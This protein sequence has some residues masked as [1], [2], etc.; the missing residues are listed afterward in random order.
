MAKFN[1][2]YY[3]YYKGYYEVEANSKEEAEEI[4]KDDIFEGRRNAPKNCYDSNCETELME[5]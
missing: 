2:R 3:E 1:V 4:V 5:E